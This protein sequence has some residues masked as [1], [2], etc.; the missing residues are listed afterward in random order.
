MEFLGDMT[1]FPGFASLFKHDCMSIYGITLLH[2]LHS[3][4][5]YSYWMCITF[6]AAFPFAVAATD[7]QEH[8]TILFM[9]RAISF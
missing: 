9:V 2:T 4:V 5:S 3:R 6:V 1:I 7:A 8:D